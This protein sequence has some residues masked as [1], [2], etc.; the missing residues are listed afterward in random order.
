VC[1][2][3]EL[4]LHYLCDNEGETVEIMPSLYNTPFPYSMSLSRYSST[5]HFVPLL[6]FHS[7]LKHLKR[8][9]HYNLR[10]LG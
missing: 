3:P 1:K 6:R 8:T 2:R 7:L 5:L 10:V 4:T 9:L